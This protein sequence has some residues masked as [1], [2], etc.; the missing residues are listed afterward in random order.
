MQTFHAGSRYP[1]RIVIKVGTALLTSGST[2]INASRIEEYAESI[3]HLRNSG[4][5]VALVSSGAISAGVA[6]LG[7]R[8]RPQS[9]PEKQ[10]TAAVGQPLLM[11][12][13][14]R[15]FRSKGRTIGQVLLTRDDFAVRPRYLNAK[16]TFAPL[17]SR[18][19]PGN[20]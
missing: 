6:A 17:F 19:R 12:A 9:I 2:G 8:E 10:A 20:Q 7:L 3:S 15:A 1:R 4:T 5:H 16:R 11:A 14:E 18:R 13:Y